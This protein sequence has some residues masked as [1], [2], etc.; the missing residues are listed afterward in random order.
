MAQRPM[1]D[2]GCISGPSGCTQT[3]MSSLQL[4]KFM[5]SIRC[6]RRSS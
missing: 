4:V 5:L 6:I 1:A 2:F 3:W